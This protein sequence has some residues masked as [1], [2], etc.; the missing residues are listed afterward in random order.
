MYRTSPA[1]AT[2]GQTSSANGTQSISST[3]P[4]TAPNT[5]PSASGNSGN[6]CR[7]SRSPRRDTLA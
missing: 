5:S 4:I 3:I 1:R 6:A 2:C 7:A